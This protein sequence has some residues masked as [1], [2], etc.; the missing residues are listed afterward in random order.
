MNNETKDIVTGKFRKES[1]F[2]LNLLT[3]R[4]KQ[5]RNPRSSIEKLSALLVLPHL[6]SH[7]PKC[8]LRTSCD[9][10]SD[11]WKA[12]P[13]RI[14]SSESF[15]IVSKTNFLTEIQQA[16]RGGKQDAFGEGLRIEIM[17]EK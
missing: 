7:H 2:C 14:D 4:L 10:V 12:F 6:L 16:V 5:A 8:D 15:K 13:K 3:L 17:E 11:N 9:R 1:Y